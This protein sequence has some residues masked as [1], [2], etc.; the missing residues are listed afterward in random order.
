MRN[1]LF[2]LAVLFLLT[3]CVSIPTGSGEKIKVSKSGVEIE[4]EDGDKANISIDTDNGGQTITFDDGTTSKIGTDAEVPED[5]PKDVLIPE[6]GNL[7]SVTN[8]SAEG[9]YSVSLIY[10]VKDEIIPL[11]EHYRTYLND[12]GYEI[13]EVELGE[14]ISLQ[15][16]KGDTSLMYQFM[17]KK[18]DHFTLM[19][20][21]NK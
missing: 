2:I 4:G 13:N 11:A 7:I 5:F 10:E 14:T 19:I 9:K 3:G 20:M 17:G 18:D 8:L 16:R 21:Y 1:S 12:N 15:G 6:D